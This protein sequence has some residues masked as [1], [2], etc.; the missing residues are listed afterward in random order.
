MGFGSD[1]GI[2]LRHALAH[3]PELHRRCLINGELPKHVA[4]DLGLDKAQ[5]QG[6][7]RMLRSLAYVPSPERCAVVVMNDW[8][9]EDEDIAEIFGRTPLWARLVRLGASDLREAEPIWRHMEYLDEGLRP[10][11]PCPEEIVRRAAIEREK[12][13]SERS[14]LSK[15]ALTQGGMRQYSWNGRNASF[16]PILADKWTKRGA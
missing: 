9:L 2:V 14:D 5:V 15:Y 10:N 7:V 8:G 4:L 6:A 1:C 16:V 13:E 11:D 12:R 3:A